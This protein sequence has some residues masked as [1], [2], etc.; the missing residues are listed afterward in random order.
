MSLHDFCVTPARLR[1]LR[2]RERPT[3][4]ST[5]D[6]ETRTRLLPNRTGLVISTDSIFGNS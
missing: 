6:M 1:R 5:P 4:P 3:R 2:A